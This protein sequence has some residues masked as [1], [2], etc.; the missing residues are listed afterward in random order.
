M[1]YLYRRD[2][3]L[4]TRKVHVSFRFGGRLPELVLE[5]THTMVNQKIQTTRRVF[6]SAVDA[7]FLFLFSTDKTRDS[8]RE[9]VAGD[10]GG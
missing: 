7:A 1:T 9:S 2:C 3:S 10:G 4:D 8:R 5:G 6:L